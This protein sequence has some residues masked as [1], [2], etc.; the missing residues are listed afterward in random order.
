MFARVRKSDSRYSDLR[1]M[2]RRRCTSQC[3]VLNNITVLAVHEVDKRSVS[4]KVQ[5][6]STE[7]QEQNTRHSK[8]VSALLEHEAVQGFAA[9]EYHFLFDDYL[10]PLSLTT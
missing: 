9:S 2:R 8:Q 10:S 4:S 6:D 5:H 7:W 1:R 3:M